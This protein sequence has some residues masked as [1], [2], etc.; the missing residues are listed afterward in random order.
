MTGVSHH[1]GHNMSQADA[2]SVAGESIRAGQT[3]T[4][5]YKNHDHHMG[6][7]PKDEQKNS[8]VTGD[9][10]K[11]QNAPNLMDLPQDDSRL[12]ADQHVQVRAIGER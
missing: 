3:G 8:V 6:P 2:N 11:T 9:A 4:G 1:L 5:C 12:E 7:K 10:P